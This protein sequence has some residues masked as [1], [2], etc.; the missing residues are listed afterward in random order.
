MP[1]F[2]RRSKIIIPFLL[3]ASS[4]FSFSCHATS[5]QVE[6]VSVD[7]TSEKLPPMAYG[8]SFFSNDLLNLPFPYPGIPDFSIRMPD[9]ESD[10]FIVD[11][12]LSEEEG[13]CEYVISNPKNMLY[14]SLTT[15]F[16]FWSVLS[17]SCLAVYFG[18]KVF[19]GKSI[20]SIVNPGRFAAADTESFSDG[21]PEAADHAHGAP[22][23]T[24][25][26]RQTSTQAYDIHRVRKHLASGKALV[27]AK[28]DI[29]L[30]SMSVEEWVA[31]S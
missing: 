15:S 24:T 3:F 25:I 9:G 1:L 30:Q 14:N 23:A 11:R 22:L 19:L 31:M 27:F 18:T 4:I 5:F 16:L 7:V 20:F 28:L 10:H 6:K 26:R 8:D 17:V 21:V 2:T 12:Y 13:S 29:L